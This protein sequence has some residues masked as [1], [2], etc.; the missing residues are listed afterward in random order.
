MKPND[1]GG[2]FFSDYFGL[3]GSDLNDLAKK[4]FDGEK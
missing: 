3:F 2:E 1:G 4:Y